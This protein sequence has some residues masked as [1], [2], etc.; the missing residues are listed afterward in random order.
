[1]A[2]ADLP[3]QMNVTQCQIAKSPP[4]LNLPPKSPP[5]HTILGVVLADHQRSSE[6]P[7]D[8]ILDS[9]EIP[10]GH[11]FILKPQPEDA[12]DNMDSSALQ[13]EHSQAPI[14]RGSGFEKII[15]KQ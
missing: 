5:R 4:P 6:E 7:E 14:L 10:V 9:S 1:M 11:P 15:F 12:R 13:S 3:F 8:V 2:P